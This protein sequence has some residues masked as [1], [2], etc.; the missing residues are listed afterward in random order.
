MATTSYTIKAVVVNGYDE[1][2][3]TDMF[4]RDAGPFETDVFYE[5]PMSMSDEGIIE[6]YT[7]LHEDFV[8]E[9]IT[10]FEVVKKSVYNK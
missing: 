2:G 10:I 5:E 4:L 6:K 1:D 7:N 3:N 8:V 9:Q